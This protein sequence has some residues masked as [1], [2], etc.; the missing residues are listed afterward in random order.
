M[1][2]TIHHPRHATRRRRDDGRLIRAEPS[3]NSKCTRSIEFA[4]R[5]AK[6]CDRARIRSIRSFAATPSRVDVVRRTPVRAR[7][8]G[9]PTDDVGRSST[10]FEGN[11]AWV[12]AVSID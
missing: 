4:R 10:S 8:C 5:G 2:F 11:C 6:R 9:P 12:V 3:W 7:V 1:V